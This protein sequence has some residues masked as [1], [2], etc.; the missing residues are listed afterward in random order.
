MQSVAAGSTDQ[1][2]GLA[3]VRASMDDVGALTRE[4]EAAAQEVAATAEAMARHADALQ[5]LVA[6]FRVDAAE[7]PVGLVA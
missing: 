2:H 3:E 5:R 6:R 1:W 7:P 4:N